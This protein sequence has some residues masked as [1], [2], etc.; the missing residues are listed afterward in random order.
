MY[1]APAFI[2]RACLRLLAQVVS[3]LV[4]SSGECR[5]DRASAVRLGQDMVSHRLLKPLCAGYDRPE[6]TSA[7]G[8]GG[9]G[10]GNG[11]GG[12]GAKSGGQSGGKSGGEHRSLFRSFDDAVGWLFAYEGDALRD[13][14]AP[15]P[16]TQVAVMT[17]TSLDVRITGWIEVRARERVVLNGIGF[18]HFFVLRRL[19][20]PLTR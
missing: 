6:D 19:A 16:A 17:G 2:P 5:G 4:T 18:S 7:A 12:S 11:S 13:P 1:H 15:P 3:W 10:W 14:F 9:A 8:G 20:V